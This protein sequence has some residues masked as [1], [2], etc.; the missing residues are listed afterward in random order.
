M[1][2]YTI[3]LMQVPMIP[4]VIQHQ[5]QDNIVK[6]QTLLYNESDTIR[7][8]VVGSSL[9]GRLV[10]DSIPDF[11]NLSFSGQSIFDGLNLLRHKKELPENIFIEMN[12]VT[13][14]ESEDFKTT[15]FSPVPYTLRKY[16]VSLRDD[17]Q[18]LAIIGNCLKKL[19]DRLSR[20]ARAL[21]GVKTGIMVEAKEENKFSKNDLFQKMLD[22]Q[23]KS[24]SEKPD[25]DFLNKQIHLLKD[26]VLFLRENKCQVIFFEMPVDPVLTQ[27]PLAKNIRNEFHKHFPKTE[28]SYIEMPD[29]LEYPTGDGVHLLN[30]AAIKY[31]SYFRATAKTIMNKQ[32]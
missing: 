16:I 15:L 13:R 25:E 23:V 1:F 12:V 3:L 19:L 18:P 14:R 28:F 7:N 9:S 31:T 5:W 10:M 27:L 17:R 8:I 21:F 11:Y 32:K 26:H 30:D 24:Y 4:K 29:C 6:A 2:V 22:L 20:L